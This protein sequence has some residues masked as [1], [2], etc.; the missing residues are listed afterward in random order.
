MVRVPVSEMF[1]IGK[2]LLNCSENSFLI[3]AVLEE[4]RRAP[5]CVLPWPT[6]AEHVG[7]ILF[8]K[9]ASRAFLG[10]DIVTFGVF[11]L[12]IGSAPHRA[13]GATLL[14]IQLDPLELKMLLEWVHRPIPPYDVVL[15]Y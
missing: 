8:T 6:H 15:V 5:V 4:T 2:F 11:D 13:N 9:I 10:I 12:N 3:L 14:R 1:H 7:L